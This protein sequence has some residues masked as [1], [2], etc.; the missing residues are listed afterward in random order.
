MSKGKKRELEKRVNRLGRLV[1]VQWLLER[2]SFEGKM[3]FNSNN[4]HDRVVNFSDHLK[5]ML[6]S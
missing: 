5:R 1:E 3:L 4:V 2:V 6:I